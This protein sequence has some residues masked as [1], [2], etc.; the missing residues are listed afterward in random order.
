MSESAKESGRYP[1][2]PPVYSERGNAQIVRRHILPAVI[3][4]LLT[5]ATLELA[6]L[7]LAESSLSFLGLGVQPPDISWEL[8]VSDGRNNLIEA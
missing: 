6:I 5:V 2:L 8:M 4:T 3:P 7:M 1:S